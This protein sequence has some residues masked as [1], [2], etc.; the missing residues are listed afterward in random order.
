[1]LVFNGGDHR[2]DPELSSTFR[3]NQ[4][5]QGHVSVIVAFTILSPG[6]RISLVNSP[7]GC[8][9]HDISGDVLPRL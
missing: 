5:G 6:E 9:R 1:M 3:E 8:V 7:F 2:K 4:R